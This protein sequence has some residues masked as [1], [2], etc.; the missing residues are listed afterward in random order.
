MGDLKS[1]KDRI[2]EFPVIYKPVGLP[3]QHAALAAIAM[4]GNKHDVLKEAAIQAL[5]SAATTNPPI[6]ELAEKHLQKI[7]K[8]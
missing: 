3:S 8:A 5:Q 4:L 6:K 2:G 1:L 7:F